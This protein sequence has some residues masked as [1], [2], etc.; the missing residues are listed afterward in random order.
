MSSTASIPLAPFERKWS[1]DGEITVNEANER[2]Y[3][4]PGTQKE[5][6]LCLNA[7]LKG[8]YLLLAGAGASGKT[9]R[10]LWL[11]QKLEAMGY[12]AL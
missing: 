9:T 2:Y 12:W 1:I 7:V 3:V 10:L 6:E 8:T 5:T 4:D 11:Q